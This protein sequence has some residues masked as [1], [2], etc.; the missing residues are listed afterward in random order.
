MSEFS[1]TLRGDELR[2]SLRV[3]L[4]VIAVLAVGQGAW[5]DGLISV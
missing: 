5:L 3:I 1:I 2:G 4:I